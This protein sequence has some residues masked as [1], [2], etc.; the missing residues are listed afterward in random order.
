[1]AQQ[2]TPA[3]SQQSE[4]APPGQF[5]IMDESMNEKGE[6]GSE[7]DFDTFLNQEH[8]RRAVSPG[9][10]S[11]SS[12]VTIFDPTSSPNRER[13][14]D[15]EDDLAKD[16]APFLSRD[17]EKDE[18][19][20]AKPEHVT[21]M[22]LPHKGQLLILFMCRF[23]DFL[24]VASL[25]A[26]VFYQLKHLAEQRTI[27]TG[28]AEAILSDSQIS[29]QAGLLTG[30]FTGAQVLTAIAWG[31]AA[32][33]SRWWGGRKMVLLI[34]TLGTAIGC[35]G[36][37]FSQSFAA[38]MAWRI[39]SGSVNGLVGIIRTMISEITVERK[40]QSRAFLILPMSFNV[41]GILGPIIGGWLAAPAMTLPGWFGPG[42]PFHSSMIEA[43]PFALPSIMN[44]VFLFVTFLAVFF[45]LEETSKS[46]KN[47]FDPGLYAVARAK[48][49]V[50]RR[51]L[52][53][54]YHSRTGYSE[55]RLD[56]KS[57]NPQPAVVAPKK[58]KTLPFSRLWTKNVI[59]TLLSQA[60]YD[61][62]LGAFTNIWS[63]FLSSPRPGFAPARVDSAMPTASEIES[64]GLGKRNL[65]WF[66]GGLGM[67]AS[68]VGNATSILGVLGMLLQVVMYP[69][70]HARLG[71][72]RSFRYFLIIFPVAYLLAPFLAVMPQSTAED[73]T[74]T[75]STVLWFGIVF[76]LFLHTSAR[77]MTL[78]ASIILLNNCSPHPSVL[79][80]IHG[81]GQSVSAGFRTVGPIVGGYWYGV[82]LDWGMV[83]FS[84][85]AVGAVAV[86]GWISS[87]MLYEGSGKEIELEDDEE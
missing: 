13:Y 43:Y 76:I 34:G 75:T 12:S 2:T 24:Q 79:G 9:V 80:T 21:W 65:L 47:S 7:A 82:G 14:F 42:A 6:F 5:D 66:A 16:S 35:F 77:T 11:S 29:A 67:P 71:T 17:L 57:E 72:L 15:S 39:F 74:T 36:Y 45:G 48:A 53:Y 18:C 46:K 31:K 78:P 86:G 59:C 4:L 20:K 1:M 81:I 28:G 50:L 56:E 73:G 54:V 70:V 8:A 85:W 84:W 37:G 26:Y 51:P 19:K 32:D 41:A 63:L 3:H 10:A 64:R 33:S 62:H 49:F 87:L 52:D 25:Q 83:A 40:Y 44:A 58:R 30:C 38:A 69:P 60:F 55:L 23:V 27:Q 68:T 61:F 22:S